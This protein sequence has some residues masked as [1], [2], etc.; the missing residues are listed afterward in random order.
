ML[1]EDESGQV[2]QSTKSFSIKPTKEFLDW[3]DSFNNTSECKPIYRYQQMSISFE[4][5]N[6]YQKLHFMKIIGT[7]ARVM[8]K[9]TNRI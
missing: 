3:T 8:L 7:P 5:V 6:L 4:E 1:C 2:S 9:N